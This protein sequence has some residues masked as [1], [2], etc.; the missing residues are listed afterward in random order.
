MIS[1]DLRHLPESYEVELCHDQ[2]YFPVVVGLRGDE[3]VAIL[4]G[5]AGHIGIRGRLD[6]VR[7]MDGGKTWQAPRV[8]VDS[9][10]DD[11]N[12]AAGLAT[13]G[14]LILA[15]HAQGSYNAQ[16]HFD[17]SLKHAQA[18]LT[19]SSDGGFTWTPTHPLGYEPYSAYSPYGHIVALPD[20]TLFM[21]IYGPQPGNVAN[22]IAVRDGACLVRSYDNGQTWSDPS[23]IALGY[24]ETALA[25]LPN[26]DALAAVRSDDRG[27]MLAVC[28]SSDGGRTWSKPIQITAE[29]EHPADLTVLTNGWI[30]MVFGIRHDPLGIHALISRNNGHTW[31]VRRLLVADSLPGPDLGYPSIARSGD[32]LVIVYYSAPR[33]EWSQ[34]DDP[35]GCVARALLVS[36]RQLVRALGDI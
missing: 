24:N 5:G 32:H 21:P 19:L 27:Q 10:V 17:S 23:C 20:G 31:D 8:I 34:A 18:R 14:T 4:R 36:E 25:I 13:D 26:G 30:L 2:G 3:V 9:E 29:L 16:G 33:R 7:S 22:E 6:L 15:Y 1:L 28:R 11:R 12:P 35:T